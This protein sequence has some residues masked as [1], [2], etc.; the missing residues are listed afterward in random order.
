[1]AL[2]FRQAGTRLARGRPDRSGRPG[3]PGKPGRPG[4]PGRATKGFADVVL[5]CSVSILKC[6]VSILKCSVSILK[7][8]VSILK[9][10]VSITFVFEHLDRE[11]SN[12]S[13]FE[14]TGNA[15]GSTGVGRERLSTLSTNIWVERR[16]VRAYLST[17]ETHLDRQA[18]SESAFE[19]IRNRLDRQVS[20]ESAFQHSGDAFGS[21]GAERERISAFPKS[22]WLDKRRARAHLRVSERHLDRQTSSESV[23]HQ[24]R[25]AF[26]ATG[27]ERERI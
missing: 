7:C 21:T 4:R 11:A 1:M 5:K 20:S 26:G 3:R 9:C 18:S 17:W 6:S 23:F 25:N 15:F 10:S 27:V 13:A 12:E 22:I 24:S 8:S 19:R 16:R 2:P 14:R